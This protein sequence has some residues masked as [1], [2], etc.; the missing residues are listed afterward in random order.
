MLPVLLDLKFVKIYTFGV[1]LVLG[2]FWSAFLLWRNIRLTSHKEEDVFDGLF[3]S[4]LGGVFIGRLMY[5][6][7]N[8]NDFGFDFLKFILI[9]GYPGISLIGAI[10]GGIFTLFGFFSIRKID[11]SEIIDYF[12]SPLFVALAFGKL[13]SFFS[14]VD[15]GAKT[16]FFLRI[17]YASFEGLR[18]LTAFYEALLF[19]VA[20]YL[21]YRLLFE[22]RKE[23]L[24]KGILLMF[25]FWFFALTYFI[26]DIFKERTLYLQG[27]SFNLAASGLMLLTTSFYFIYHSEI[28]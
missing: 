19:G 11:F 7:L 27:I 2:F 16:T 28:L 12:I 3:W 4:L 20:A 14:G 22:I 24:K 17:R 25:F 13:G 8:F 26:F 21:S 6:V 10:L 1:F 18:H 9:N 15:V 23:R 5:V